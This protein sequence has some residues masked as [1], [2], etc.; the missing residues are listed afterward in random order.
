MFEWVGGIRFVVN[1][2]T[3]RFLQTM[4]KNF[5]SCRNTNLSSSYLMPCTK[6]FNWKLWFL[7]LRKT[8]T[9]ETGVASTKS[10]KGYKILTFTGIQKRYRTGNAIVPPLP[11]EYYL[12]KKL[13]GGGASSC[14]NQNTCQ[15]TSEWV[16]ATH[17]PKLACKISRLMCFPSYCS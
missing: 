10:H 11:I 9:E 16:P 2:S 7:L 3:T 1:E 6:P 17:A 8:F 12:A 15:I 13:K 4:L 5:T 14:M